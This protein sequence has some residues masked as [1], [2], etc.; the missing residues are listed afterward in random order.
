[1]GQVSVSVQRHPWQRLVMRAVNCCSSSPVLVIQYQPL[2]VRR[3]TGR[4]RAAC[5]SGASC[6]VCPQ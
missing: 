4:A 1:M 2:S 5:Y 6:L 3:V